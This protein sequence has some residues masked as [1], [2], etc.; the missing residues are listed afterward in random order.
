MISSHGSMSTSSEI[1][2]I[3]RSS[4][5]AAFLHGCSNHSDWKD[6]NTHDKDLENILLTPMEKGGIVVLLKTD[7]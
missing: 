1:P 5:S 2:S 4:F 6:A 3:D 7:I